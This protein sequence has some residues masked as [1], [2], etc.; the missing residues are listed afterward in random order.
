MSLWLTGEAVWLAVPDSTRD[1]NLPHAASPE[2]LIESVL[3]G[4]KI[5]VCTQCALR[6]DL[7]ESD[8]RAGIRIAGVASYLEEV[9]APD[10][11]ALV[12]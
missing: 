2:D 4:G 1:F 8:L 5:T 7:T 10:T 9:L 6:R 3:V 12:Y 11:Q